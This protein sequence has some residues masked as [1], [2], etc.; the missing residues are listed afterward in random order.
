VAAVAVI[1]FSLFTAQWLSL[2][3]AD[4]LVASILKLGI[5]DHLICAIQAHNYPELA[6]PPDQIRTKL[7]PRYAPLLQVVQQRLPGFDVLEGHICSIPNSDRK[8]VHFIT[9]GHGTILSVILTERSGATFPK[10][11][12][13]IT[14][15]SGGLGIYENRLSGME[16]AGFQS[17]QYFAFVVSDLDQKELLQLARGLAPALNETLHKTA[18]LLPAN[19]TKDFV[20]LGSTRG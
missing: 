11:K 17:G 6:N 16:I 12:L 5:S 10:G 20:K 8:Y 9:R 4:Q 3:R 2:R 1:V 19:A 7:G 13:L 15:D 14:A 18:P